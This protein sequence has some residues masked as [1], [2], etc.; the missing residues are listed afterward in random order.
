MGLGCSTVVERLPSILKA[1]GSISST[2]HKKQFKEKIPLLKET[3][4]T[5]CCLHRCNETKQEH[6]KYE[7][8]GKCT[9]QMITKIK[10]IN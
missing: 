6:F 5:I 10:Q 3:Y 9:K 7:P 4:I 8:M 1:L 2:T